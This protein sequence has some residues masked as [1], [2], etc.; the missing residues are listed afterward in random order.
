MILRLSR[1]DCHPVMH[2]NTHSDNG[3]DL[4]NTMW[5][6]AFDVDETGLSD[7][8]AYTMWFYQN[9][10]PNFQTATYWNKSLASNGAGQPECKLQYFHLE[11]AI[12]QKTGDWNECQAWHGSSCCKNTTVASIAAINE[13]YGAQYHIDRCGPLSQACENYFMLE[14]CFYECDPTAG[15][16]RR[17]T[18]AQVAADIAANGSMTWTNEWEMYQM[19][20]RASF[21]NAWYAACYDDLFCSAAGGNFFSCAMIYDDDAASTSAGDSSDDDWSREL[22]IITVVVG[23]VGLMLLT[24]VGYLV[25]RERSGD[26]L[27]KPLKN[28]LEE[29]D[30]SS[31]EMVATA[32]GITG[33]HDDN[34]I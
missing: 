2:V 32:A 28:S 16:Y 27:F 22:T 21:C 33:G 17:Y 9:D 8:N 3:A 34:Q 26:A 19:P 7:D 6:E 24:L 23:V 1:M 10:N 5:G 13:A 12:E 30:P 29:D 20:I 15:M 11:Y 4:C 18:D 31:G 14:N 25:Y